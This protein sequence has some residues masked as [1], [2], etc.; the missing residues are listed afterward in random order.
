MPAHWMH[1][2]LNFIPLAERL[3][4][5]ESLLGGHKAQLVALTL[6]CAYPRD[7]QQENVLKTI[8]GHLLAHNPD[9]TPDDF[10]VCWGWKDHILSGNPNEKSI[11][12][13]S[14]TGC[15]LGPPPEVAEVPA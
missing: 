15:T 4:P 7:M 9:L 14:D 6:P 10:N 13:V 8:K 12:F 5:L 3:K 1:C 11:L 2:D